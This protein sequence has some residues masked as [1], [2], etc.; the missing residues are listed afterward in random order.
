MNVLF[1]LIFFCAST[2]LSQ[3]QANISAIAPFSSA[4]VS[5]QSQKQGREADTKI[6]LHTFGFGISTTDGD[7]STGKQS[8][9][10][11]AVYAYSW[12]PTVDFETSLQQMSMSKWYSAFNT[13][14]V[15]SALSH[16]IILI[17]RPLSFA[18]KFL[19]GVGSSAR[20]QKSM[21]SSSTSTYDP[22]TMQ[23]FSRQTLNGQNTFAVGA[24]VK[25]E[26][27]FSLSPMFDI[28]IRA[29]GHIYAPPVI[30]DNNHVPGDSPG[31]AASLGLFLLIHP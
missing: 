17:L 24:T 11:S 6:R 31:G 1:C 28:S 26:Y 13:F 16:D 7:A 2:A 25:L 15:S 5:E 30:G 3:T 9:M 18:P 19:L 14:A 10:L 21:V 23:Y 8:F 27:L 22:M 20:W 12:L 4:A 29:Q